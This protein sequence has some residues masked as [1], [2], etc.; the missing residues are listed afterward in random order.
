MNVGDK[1]KQQNEKRTIRKLKKQ[2]SGI[3]EE[4]AEVAAERLG[5]KED[6]GTIVEE[7]AGLAVERKEIK[8]GVQAIA[9]EVADVFADRTTVKETLF[10]LLKGNIG[11]GCLS[12]PWAYSQLGIPLGVFMTAVVALWTYRNCIMILQVKADH[13]S[14]R[15]TVTYSDLGEVAY[16]NSAS[17]C[18][19]KL[20]CRFAVSHL[21]RLPQF[22]V[23]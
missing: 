11:P 13:T 19:H 15:R 22:C 5:L 10:H 12:L 8:E 1:I 23:I 6:Y 14:N 21:Y 3:T 4:A 17:N 18:C 16:G 7:A 2:Y 20:Y 9:Q